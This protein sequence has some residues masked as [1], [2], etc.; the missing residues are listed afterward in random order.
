MLYAARPDSTPGSAVHGVVA[1]GILYFGVTFGWH[2]PAHRALAS[3]G[4]SV[5]TISIILR[6]QWARTFVQVFRAAMLAWLDARAMI[7]A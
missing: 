2:L 6:S 4:N 7:P 5:A 3:G 1:L